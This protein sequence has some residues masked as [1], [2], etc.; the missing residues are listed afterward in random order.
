[1][2]RR[3]AS[4]QACANIALIKYWGKRDAALNLPCTGSLSLTLA[5]LTTS[6]TVTFSE[7]LAEDVVSLDGRPAGDRERA[8]VSTFL[9]RVRDRAG[10]PLRAEV[11]SAN[12]F[13][14]ASGL[15]S[16]ASGFA[17]LARAATRAAGLQLSPVELSL[18][19]R[20]GSGAAARAFFPGFVRMHAGTQAD[21]GDAL[22]TELDAGE[23]IHR[24]RMVVAVVG[25]G[26]LKK[27]GSRDAMEH[28]ARTSP[29]FSAWVQQVPRDLDA[30]EALL[31]RRDLPALGIL[32]EENALA[33]HA[34][35][36]ASR[37]PIVYW[38]PS[39]LA[40]LS[41][42]WQLRA[43]GVAAWATMDA[44]PHVKVLTDEDHA[45]IVAQR[46]QSVEGVSQVLISAAGPGVVDIDDHR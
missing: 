27:H 16:S 17:A 13:P 8:R 34:T 28:C 33:M 15:A 23:L 26:A 40:V 38:Q 29:L 39:T 1:V 41:A 25:G 20:H 14:T 31:A 9:D 11:R 24:V 5:A 42:V 43:D 36:I 32:T 30:A 37:P 19:A 44:G 3:R 4:A 2:T 18:L 10:L 6:T 7:D 21:G 46:L 45:A 12:Q 35:A 22:A